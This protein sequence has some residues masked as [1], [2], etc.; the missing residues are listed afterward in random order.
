MDKFEYKI[1]IQNDVMV[2]T[3]AGKMDRQSLQS[4]EACRKDI[5]NDSP[6]LIILYFKDV[7]KIEHAV[8]REI[9]VLQHEIRKKNIELYLSGLDNSTRDLL[10][11]RAIIRAS[12]YKKSL[13]HIFEKRTKPTES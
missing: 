9:T 6:S 12:E 2:V 13:V 1:V 7:T 8:F 5:L 10:F 11:D 4:I 3:F